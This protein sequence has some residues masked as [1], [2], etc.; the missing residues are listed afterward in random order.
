MEKKDTFFP[1]FDLIDQE[2]ENKNSYSL[3]ITSK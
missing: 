1:E 3:Q 2:I